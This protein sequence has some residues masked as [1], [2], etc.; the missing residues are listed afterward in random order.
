MQLFE[1]MIVINITIIHDSKSINTFI[2]N[3]LS[4]FLFPTSIVVFICEFMWL[5]SFVLL[6]SHDIK[7]CFFLVI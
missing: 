4:S 1:C 2:S 6:R 7:V 3:R 5:S